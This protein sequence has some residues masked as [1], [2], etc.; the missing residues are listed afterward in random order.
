M[1]VQESSSG[2]RFNVSSVTRLFEDIND[3]L[4][5]QSDGQGITGILAISV[6]NF[7][8]INVGYGYAYG[9][10]LM[11]AVFHRLQ[12]GLPKRDRVY[13]LGRNEFVVVLTN[14]RIPQNLIRAIDKVR[15]LLYPPFSTGSSKLKVR[16]AMGATTSSGRFVNASTLMREADQALLQSRQSMLEFAVFDGNSM[17]EKEDSLAIQSN[18]ELALEREEL[19]L[20]YQPKVE[21][22]T[23][24]VVGVEALMR[25]NSPELG[26]VPPDQFI[27]AAE[28]T[29][30]IAPITEWAIKTAVKQYNDWGELGVPV[31]V[32]LSAG[33]LTDP[34]LLALIDR[35]LE[36]WGVPK[37]ALSLEITET[38]MMGNAESSINVMKQLREHGLRLSI[39]DFGTG[40]SSMAYL[41][42]LPVDELKIDKSFVDNLLTDKGDQKI[43]SAVSNL[44]RNFGLKTV[45]EGIEDFETFEYLRKLGCVIAQGYY[46][47]RPLPADEF[48]TW[49]VLWEQKTKD[50]AKERARKLSKA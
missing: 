45:A 34:H 47:S 5:S 33:V 27:L 44:A 36:I 43:V 8:R 20:V 13:W 41:K 7:R 30:L 40:Y 24:K 22:Q 12:D 42:D 16:Y 11:G 32:N 10:R 29:G 6:N 1:R 35:A 23:S 37:S 2:Q 19:S 4:S 31:A 39:D 15:E 50:Q 9:E 25:W 48:P 14:L 3:N 46:I 17:V 38:A 21:F 18:L 28:Q 49:R 26:F